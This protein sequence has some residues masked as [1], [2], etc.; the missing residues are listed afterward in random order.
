MYVPPLSMLLKRAVEL[1]GSELT[2]REVETIA[3][4]APCLEVHL[5]VALV[6]HGYEPVTPDT[7][8]DYWSQRSKDPRIS[9][10]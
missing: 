5:E 3:S 8:W 10:S 9:P 6:T 2:R 4:E 7:A 1:K